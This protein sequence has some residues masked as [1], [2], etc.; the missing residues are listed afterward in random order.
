MDR[1][2]IFAGIAALCL[3]AGI[4]ISLIGQPQQHQVPRDRPAITDFNQ[5]R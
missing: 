1:V 2:G 5:Y 4:T 3:G